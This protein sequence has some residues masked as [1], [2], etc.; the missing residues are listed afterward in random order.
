GA[1]DFCTE[2][3]LCYEGFGDGT[4]GDVA[5][6]CSVLN[7]PSGKL[8]AGLP[9]TSTA[10][11]PDRAECSGA[12]LCEITTGICVCFTGFTGDACQRTVCKDDCS[13]H[14]KCL[15]IG[16]VAHSGV[17]NALPLNRADDAYYGDITS[18][19]NEAWDFDTTQ[20]CVCDSRWT[21]GLGAGETQL[22]EYFGGD[23]SLK[24]CPSGRD[25]SASTDGLD[26]ANKTA[27]LG[28]GKGGAGNLCHVECSNRGKCN[29]EY[30]TCECYD[31]Y[32]GYNCDRLID[33]A[34]AVT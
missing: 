33:F 6:D 7:C 34:G 26:C 31:G 2:R 17:R 15:T 16:Q 13:G 28:R 19:V 29:Y 21:V 1:C 24:H 8:F 27:P 22:A 10:A 23:C 30:G 5:V 20:A 11:H 32:I 18:R 9:T 14:G 3:C 4:V 25:P 12:G